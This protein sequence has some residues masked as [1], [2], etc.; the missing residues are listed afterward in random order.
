MANSQDNMLTEEFRVALFARNTKEHQRQRS[1]HSLLKP[2]L[3]E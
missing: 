2:I 1:I 3:F